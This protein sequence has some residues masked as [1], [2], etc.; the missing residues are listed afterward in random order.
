MQ[1]CYFAAMW[2]GKSMSAYNDCISCATSF[3]VTTVDHQGQNAELCSN[4]WLPTY[5]TKAACKAA[6]V[7]PCWVQGDS[8]KACQKCLQDVNGPGVGPGATCGGM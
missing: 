1:Q 7:G 2:G 8:G 3:P 6:G 5:T 4:C